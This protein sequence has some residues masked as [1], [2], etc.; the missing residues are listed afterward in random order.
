V[1]KH[2]DEHAW[3]AAMEQ[4]EHLVVTLEADARMAG[5]FLRSKWPTQQFLKY[6]PQSLI[7]QLNDFGLQGWELVAAQPVML[8][9]NGDVTYSDTR[10]THKYLCFFKRHVSGEKQ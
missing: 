5:D 1:S 10:W 6:S 7:P 2:I 9:D 8:G 3:E 4:W